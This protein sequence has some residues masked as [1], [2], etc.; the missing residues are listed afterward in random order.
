MKINICH[1]FTPRHAIIIL[2]HMS[3]FN[4]LP[5]IIMGSV[6]PYLS[7][8]LGFAN[9]HWMI[10]HMAPIA[11]LLYLLY[12][13][14]GWYHTQIKS[15]YFW[16]LSSCMILI[17]SFL[18]MFQFA[19]ISL[20]EEFI[21]YQ[22]LYPVYQWW[23]SLAAFCFVSMYYMMIAYILSVALNSVWYLVQEE[24]WFHVLSFSAKLSS[25]IV[26]ILMMLFSAFVPEVLSV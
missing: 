6:L 7:T 19:G 21:Y 16:C 4:V 1:Q 8:Q 13:G 17:T 25:C 23:V 22:S 24:Q 26:V 9:H 15:R 14:E 5:Y 10:S 18:F 2:I 12:C 20:Q 11:T 3:L